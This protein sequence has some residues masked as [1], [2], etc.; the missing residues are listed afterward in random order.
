MV[1]KYVWMIIFENYARYSKRLS[2]EKT[3][4]CYTDGRTNRQGDFYISLQTEFPEGIIIIEIH[5]EK[6]VL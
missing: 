3:R 5:L 1:Q 2:N 6:K 4:H